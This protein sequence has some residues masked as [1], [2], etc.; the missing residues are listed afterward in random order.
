MDLY[1]PTSPDMRLPTSPEIPPTEGTPEQ[2]LQ[3]DQYGHIHGGASE[4]AFLHYTKQKLASLSTVPILFSD[5]P[6]A[7]S[8]TLP[9]ILPSKVIA[10]DIVRNYFDFGLTTSRFVHERS[11]LDQY[12]RLYSDTQTEK[13]SA[14]NAALVYMVMALG[15]HYSKHNNTFCGYASRS[16]K[17]MADAVSVQML[18]LYS[19]RFYDMANQ[20][21]QNKSSEITFASLQTRLRATHYLL[22]HSRM[23]E[24]WSSFGIVVRHAHALGLHRRSAV[25]NNNHVAY[26]YRKR[27]FWTIYINDRILSSVF[28]RPCA[29]HD[30]DIDQAECTLAN[31][32][33]ISASACR[34]TGGS[35]FCATAAMVHYARVARILGKVLRKFYSPTAR[36]MSMANLHAEAAEFEQR[37]A[38]WQDNLPSYLD[39]SSLPPSAMTV[40]IQRQMCTLKL[41]FA[42]TSLLL[43]RP[44]IVYSIGA[45]AEKT[46]GLEDWIR[47]CH[48]KAIEA[49]KTVVSKC[50]YLCR[51]GL[52]SRVF[53]L[54]NYVQFAAIGTLYTYS[55]L[56]PDTDHIREIAEEAMTQFPIGVEGD[57]VG[58]R[59]LEILTELREITARPGAKTVQPAPSFKEVPATEDFQF[60]FNGPWSNLFFDATN[61]FGH[62]PTFNDLSARLERN[63]REEKADTMKNLSASS[64]SRTAMK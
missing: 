23:H 25:Q 20:Q 10:D 19:V 47:R 48:D 36:S 17:S 26:E 40:V 22:N 50:R 59:Y 44:F 46:S 41:A 18:I 28:G 16:A 32:E 30:D 45:N 3:E 58:Q 51:H 38:V 11:L 64:S 6:L 55:H 5:Y 7:G 39:F 4:F 49:A 14:D 62:E 29:L 53:W 52:F 54:V 61:M 43:Y 27:L 9:P 57:P 2:Q 42:H 56:W 8:D 63:K 31:D 34:P 33:D 1:T 13:I 15:S 60:D 37:L 24:A 12:E 35:D 21:L